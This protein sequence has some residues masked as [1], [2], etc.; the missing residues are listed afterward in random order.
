[1]TMEA[2]PSASRRGDGGSGNPAPPPGKAQAEAGI[3]FSASVLLGIAQILI[4]G[5]SFFLL[6]VLAEPI[7][8]DTGWSMTWIYGGLTAGVLVSGLLSPQANV[9][10]ARGHGRRVLILSGWIVAAGL[11]VVGAAPGIP[12]FIAG[13]CLIGV[14]MAGG[15]Y[16][17][18]FTTLGIRHG[19]RARPVINAIT[20]IAGFATTV[21]W[22]ALAWMTGP[23]GWRATCWAYAAV[24]ALC[25]APLYL[26]AL[27]P[28]APA[29]AALPARKPAGRGR[30]ALPPGISAGDYWLL[31]FVFSIAA[32]L[33]TAVSVQI[34]VLLQ[35]AGHTL[36]SA[37]A[38][39]ALIGPSMVLMRVI[40]FSIKSLHPIWMALVSAA[41]VAIGLLLVSLDPRAAAA[42]IVCYGIGNGLRALV[43]GTLPIALVPQSALAPVMGRLA[44]S[45]LL[46]QALTPLACGFLVTHAG[47]AG[48]LWIL[49][50]LAAVNFGLTAWLHRRVKAAALR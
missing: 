21:V 1:M 28:D 36:A 9:Y 38:L 27:P 23:L 14:G 46:C 45:S 22:P 47:A 29:A 2:P 50:A 35:G 49:T 20:L 30:R 37:I 25:I 24:L 31:S 48:T 5:G 12:A 16:D 39:S 26:K 11:C 4:W 40:T 34:I 43:R 42:G 3:P 41:F 44:R 33:M 13:W 18:L 8:R 7:H 19:Q 17:P 15:L 10:I 6:S 32:L